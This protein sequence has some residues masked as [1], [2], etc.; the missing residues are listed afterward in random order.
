MHAKNNL[1]LSG[2]WA[3]NFAS[4]A[5][6]VIETL[7]EV[8][9]NTDIVFDIPDSINLLETKTY[10][11]ITVLAC[12]FQMK[13]SRYTEQNR[14]IWSRVTTPQW[15]EA[16]LRQK[17]NGAGL[18]AMHTATICFDDWNEW[19]KWIGGSWDWKHSSH[20]PLCDLNIAPCADHVIVT[21]VEPFVIRD[22]RYTNLLKDASSQVI[23]QSLGENN[24]QPTLWVNESKTGRVVYNAL[25]HDLVSVS[26]PAQKLLIKRSALWACQSADSQIKAIT[27]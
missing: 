7:S 10:D 24:A 8:G 27:L 26:H 20:P 4:S 13:D 21:E 23:L 17:N 6:N 14:E 15:Q 1:M 12:W 25:G 9:F 18:L 5:P 16:M 11:L 19:P 2:G 22:E 3:H